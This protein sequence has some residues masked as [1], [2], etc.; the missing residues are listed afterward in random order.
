[1]RVTRNKYGAETLT[2]TKKSPK[3]F[4]SSP[5]SHAWNCQKR[6]NTYNT[7]RQITKVEDI[8]EHATRMKW[9]W[10]NHIV[11]RSYD[12]WTGRILEWPPG[13]NK[14]YRGRPTTGTLER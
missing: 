11:R 3:K 7:I 8:M 5:E 4:I 12:R 6:Q 2:L 1:M 13:G 10:A 9:R 14:R